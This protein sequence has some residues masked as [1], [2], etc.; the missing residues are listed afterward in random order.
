MSSLIKTPFIPHTLTTSAKSLRTSPARF[1]FSGTTCQNVVDVNLCFIMHVYRS[2]GNMGSFITHPYYEGAH[3]VCRFALCM[4]WK[5]RARAAMIRCVCDAHMCVR[6]CLYINLLVVRFW[7]GEGW[8]RVCENGG[9]AVSWV[10]CQMG[11]YEMWKWRW[12]SGRGSLML[13]DVAGVNYNL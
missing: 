5:F 7:K 3:N 9:G 2:V 13:V 6:Y 10:H 12:C 4:R 11:K 8:G 1:F